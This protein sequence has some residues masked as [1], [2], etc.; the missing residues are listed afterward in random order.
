MTW[1]REIFALLRE[2]RRLTKE[3]NAYIKSRRNKP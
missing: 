1:V 3:I 2:D